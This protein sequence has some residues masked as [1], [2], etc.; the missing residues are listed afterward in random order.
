MD[1]RKFIKTIAAAGAATIL[2]PLS[3]TLTRK[4]AA[5][6]VY[7]GL[8][9]FIDDHPEAVFIKRTDVPIKTDSEAKKREGLELARWIFTLRDTP[10]IPLS[11]RI[12]VKPNLA[13]AKGLAD[14][15]IGMGTNTDVH[16]VE[17]LLEGIKELGIPGDQMYIREASWFGGAKEIDR[18]TTPYTG[19]AERIGA[20][21][22]DFPTGRE[23]QDLTFDTLEEG[24]EVT[25]VDCPHGVVFRRIPYIAP[26]NQP[27]TWLLNVSK[28]KAHSMGMTLSTKNLQGTCV[29]PHITFCEGVDI[30]KGYPDHIFQNFQPDLEEHID[31]LYAQHLEAA[32]PRWDRPDRTW[33]SGYRMETW[34]QRTCDSISVTNMGLNMI[35]GICGRNGN[36]FDGPDPNGDAQDF[37]TNLIIFGKN[38]FLVDIIGFWLAGHEPGNIGL[39]HIARERGLCDVINPMAIPIY[40]WE[41]GVPKPRSLEDF[42]RTPLVTPYLR[43]DYDG[44]NEPEYHLVD[45]RYCYQEEINALNIPLERGWNLFSIPFLLPDNSIETVLYPIANHYDCVYTYDAM[46]GKW[47]KHLAG[48]PKFLND[49]EAIESGKAYWIHMVDFA[50]LTLSGNTVIDVPIEL[51]QGWNMTGYNCLVTKPVEKALS[52]IPGTCDSIWTYDTTDGEWKSYFADFSETYNNLE[53]MEPG[54]G[55]YAYVK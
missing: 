38:S 28:L 8:H 17:G 55:Y 23:I 43:R 50:I 26:F 18:L 48:S 36:F 45:E 44:Q 27:D 46:N 29:R 33:D 32:I 16:F 20:H 30:T 12:A 31:A 25:W 5:D 9:P 49:L 6:P 2:E 11:Y 21:F 52:H 14:T 53:I 4:A 51:N 24:S 13:W 22:L 10:G 35:E 47:K 1:R 41:D 15:E 19:M 7:F 39:F 40:L 34:A 42:E 3:G 54:R 37:L